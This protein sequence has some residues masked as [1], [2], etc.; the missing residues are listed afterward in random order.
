MGGPSMFNGLIGNYGNIQGGGAPNPNT[1]SSNAFNNYFGNVDRY[2]ASAQNPG[3]TGT[4]NAATLEA[5]QKY[6]IDLNNI[7]NMFT[8]ANAQSGA[9]INKSLLTGTGAE[10]ARTAATLDKEI[11][12]TLYNA[13]DKS[14]SLMNSINLKGLSEG[15]RAAVERSLGQ[16][17]VATGNL[18]LDNATN[19]VTNAMS[20]G[21]RMAQKRQELNQYVNTG[22]NAAQGGINSTGVALSG[23]SAPQSNFGTSQFQN[24]G[25]TAQTNAGLS[26]SLFG[27]LTGIQTAS[28]NPTAQASWQNSDRYAMDQIGANA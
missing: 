11:N 15:E 10:N 12:P 16:S 24:A 7:G 25:T 28:I 22:L 2:L 26:N 5:L 14:N 8:A 17:Q 13:R 4:I 20:Y 27:N 19:A 1:L 23:T 18:G 21:D 3:Q 6:G 9:D